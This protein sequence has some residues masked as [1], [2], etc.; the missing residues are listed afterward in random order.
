MHP[1]LI[2][3]TKKDD[4]KARYERADRYRLA[5]E[6]PS[7]RSRS[8]KSLVILLAGTGLTLA[9]WVAGRAEA[10]RMALSRFGE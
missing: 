9:S 10:V 2:Y 7:Q 6:I 4:I 3:D 5:A 1:W 8:P